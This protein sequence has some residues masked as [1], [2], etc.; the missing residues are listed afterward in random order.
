MRF[1]LNRLA[2]FDHISVAFG[3]D[4]TVDLFAADEVTVQ[5]STIEQSS[6]LGGASHNYGLLNGPDGFGISVHHNLFAHNSNRNP[7]IANG[8]ADVRNNVAY[9]VKHGFV[10]HNRATGPFNIIGNYYRQGPN[11]Q[12]HPFFFDDENGGAALDLRYYLRNNY[13]DDPGDLVGSID[14][15]WATPLAHS[16]FGS[17]NLPENPYRVTTEHD[18]TGYA[19]YVA[20]TTETATAAYNTVLDK[21]GAWPRDVVT[22]KSV[23]DSRDRTGAWGAVVPSITGLMDGLT[24][25]TAPVDADNDGM[26]DAWESAHGLNPTNGNDHSTVMPSG[27]TAIEEYINEL[28]DLL[29]P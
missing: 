4:E 27:Y 19:G 5:Y 3:V 20:V 21:A 15:P 9:N 25:G 10:H 11:D 28:A 18:F 12:L 16:T 1:S 26:A 2:I 24:P 22:K 7:A 8:P 14:N 29:V 17:L 13:I 6:T 23:Q